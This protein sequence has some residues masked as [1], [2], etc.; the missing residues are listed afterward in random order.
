MDCSPEGD[1]SASTHPSSR[2]CPV[3]LR[4]ALHQADERG[5]CGGEAG[6]AAKG[7]V[8]HCYGSRS[9]CRAILSRSRA[10]KAT[11][12]SP[13]YHKEDDW[14]CFDTGQTW[15]RSRRPLGTLSIMIKVL[16]NGMTVCRS[17]APLLENI[18]VQVH[19]ETGS[20]DKKKGS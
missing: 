20:S 7:P 14:A 9:H 3:A 10:R 17:S 1:A 18:A 4:W 19:I 8:G 16:I 6:T 13:G 11:I 2:K 12:N 15:Y 5:S